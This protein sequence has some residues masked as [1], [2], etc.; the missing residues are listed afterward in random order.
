MPQRFERSTAVIWVDPPL[1][2]FF[3]R[4]IKRSIKNDACREGNLKGAT[5]Q[6]NLSLITYTMFNYPRNSGKYQRLLENYKKPLIKINSM[7]ELNR[8]YKDWEI[9]FRN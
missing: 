5:N 9:K 3:W 4:Y 8:Y 1:F 6:F 7:K 2:G